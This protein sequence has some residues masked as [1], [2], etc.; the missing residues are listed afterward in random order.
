MIKQP[1]YHLSAIHW[2]VTRL[3]QQHYFLAVNQPQT[4]NIIK[5]PRKFRI[6]STSKQT[7]LNFCDTEILCEKIATK[8]HHYE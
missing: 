7:L 2:Q 1:R 3:S 6:R 8:R 5:Q 4:Q